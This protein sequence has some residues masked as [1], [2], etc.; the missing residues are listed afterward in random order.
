MC[1]EGLGGGVGVGFLADVGVAVSLD[2]TVGAT[3]GRWGGRRSRCCYGGD[4]VRGSSPFKRSAGSVSIHFVAD[5]FV[6]NF[7]NFL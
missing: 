1:G 7:G 6:A 3:V 4:F 2:L 5:H